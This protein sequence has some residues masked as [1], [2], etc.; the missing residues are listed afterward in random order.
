L[1]IDLRDRGA[2]LGLLDW[3]HPSDGDD[4]PLL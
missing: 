4:E 3:I 2:D 1:D